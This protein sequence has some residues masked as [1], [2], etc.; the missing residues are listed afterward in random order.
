MRMGR[1]RM[2]GGEGIRVLEKRWRSAK[3]VKIH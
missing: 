3:E 2:E 1:T